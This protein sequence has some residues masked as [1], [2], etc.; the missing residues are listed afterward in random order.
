MSMKFSSYL[1]FATATLISLSSSVA[2]ADSSTTVGLSA[3]VAD[4]CSFG[5]VTNVTFPT[6]YEPGQSGT[7][8]GGGSFVINCTVT[9]QAVTLTP[10]GGDNAGGSLGRQ[11]IHE[12]DTSQ[13]LTYSLF[14]SDTDGATA[15]NEFAVSAGF[16]PPT[17]LSNGDNTFLLE[18]LIAGSQSVVGGAYGDSV[19][20]TM[21]F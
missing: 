12:T 3:S 8:S 13:L 18:A 14:V 11:L 19:D 15:D 21:S 20:I 17:N 16:V 4:A 7:L 1:A 5:T 6:E 2:I 9:N 10:D